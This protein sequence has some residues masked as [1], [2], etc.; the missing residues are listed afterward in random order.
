MAGRVRRGLAAQLGPRAKGGQWGPSGPVP[1]GCL[2]SE[3][4]SAEREKI[5]LPRG[6]GAPG[7]PEALVKYLVRGTVGSAQ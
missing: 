2:E 3:Q 4:T 5:E 6:V 7:P 1:G